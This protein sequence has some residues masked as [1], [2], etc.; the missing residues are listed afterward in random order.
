MQ[1]E[2]LYFTWELL[3]VTTRW[4]QRE[5]RASFLGKFFRAKLHLC[6]LN[7]HKSLVL[8]KIRGKKCIFLQI[9]PAVSLDL[10]KSKQMKYRFLWKSKSED[11][12]ERQT[13]LFI[14]ETDPVLLLLRIKR[15]SKPQSSNELFVIVKLRS[16]FLSLTGLLL[17]KLFPLFFSPLGALEVIRLF[18]TNNSDALRTEGLL[19][20]RGSCP[21]VSPDTSSVTN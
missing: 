21:F 2:I 1:S 14:E 11:V 8:G 15:R 7:S 3:R 19:S 18:H 13:L 9:I 4:E 5:S 17:N 10:D 6:L 16:T 20:G 12:S